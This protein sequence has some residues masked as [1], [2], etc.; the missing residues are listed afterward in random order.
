MCKGQKCTAWLVQMKGT[1]FE[2][3]VNLCCT[4]TQELP[5]DATH[6]SLNRLDINQMLD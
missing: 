3:K 5:L 2:R 1:E 6:A 4:L